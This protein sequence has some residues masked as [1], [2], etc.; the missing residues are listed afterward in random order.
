MKLDRSFYLRSGLD[1]A[2]D[3]IGKQFVHHSP[4]GTTKGIIVEVEAYMGHDIMVPLS[5]PL[6]KK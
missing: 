2:R 6:L 3:L 5:R 4:E 1:V